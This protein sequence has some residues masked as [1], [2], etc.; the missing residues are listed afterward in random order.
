MEK[1]KG[2]K[3]INKK[4]SKIKNLLS[5]IDDPTHTDLLFEIVSF[6][7]S[8]NRLDDPEFKKGEVSQKTNCRIG[9]EL[10]DD[11]NELVKMGYLEKGKY[12]SYKLLKHIWN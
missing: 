9:T 11:L 12:S 2:I 10:I 3:K 7:E 8:E 1:T 5:I 4:R 6:L